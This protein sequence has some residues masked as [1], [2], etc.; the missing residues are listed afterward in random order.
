MKRHIVW[1]MLLLV[2]LVW[3]GSGQ[4]GP[5]SEQNNAP[6]M[7]IL[8]EGNDYATRVLRD[9][10]DMNE[11]SDISASLNNSGRTNLLSNIQVSNGVFSASSTDLNQAQFYA[12]FPG[13]E[14]EMRIGKV[15]EQYPIP[16]SYHCL[17]IR[18]RVN[19][20]STSDSWHP[21]WLNLKQ[22]F[23]DGGDVAPG[24]PLQPSDGLPSR[25]WRVYFVDLSEVNGFYHHPWSSQSSWKGLGIYPTSKPNTAFS[26]DWIRLTDC[27]AVNY[28][29]SWGQPV[30]GQS[31]LWA[32]IGAQQ[33]D[34][35]IKN[36]GSNDA[37]YT[38]DVQGIAPGTYYIGIES[39]SGMTWL[40][41][42]LV[43]KPTPIVNFTR[44]SPS[45]GPDYATLAGHPWNMDSSADVPRID[46]TLASFSNGMLVLD[47]PSPT[48][49]TPLPGVRCTGQEL[50][51]ADPRLFLY[52]P[53]TPFNG[54]DYRYLS[55]RMFINGNMQEVADGMIGR[56]IWTTQTG[57]T[58]VSKGI[59]YDVGWHT[60][61]VDLFDPAQGSP[62]QG[63]CVLQPWSSATQVTQLRFDPNENYTGM[64]Y[65]PAMA[66]HQEYDW[67]RLT[68]V[69]R[70]LHGT[71]FPIHI[72][73]NVPE[74]QIKSLNFYYTTSRQEPTQHSV[75]LYVPPSPPSTTNGRF[76]LYLP[77]VVNGLGDAIS[78]PA[79]MWETGNVA[80]GTYYVCANVSDGYNQASYCS[81]APL[82]IQ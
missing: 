36:L 42:N 19:S 16:S 10:W 12:L 5:L 64:G 20:P 21:A 41:N 57:C 8:P 38:W 59:P 30:G 53:M 18:M 72:S 70:V 56:W 39:S 31:K 60:Y 62:T 45:S 7:T 25:S 46:C 37:S 11:F 74:D 44:P 32:G 81:D 69:D 28:S 77:L 14:F 78:G 23:S 63:S 35:L 54:A 47:T 49:P 33:K 68:Q 52:T 71:A 43:I 17:Y 61:S 22:D 24:I 55:F 6:A 13:Y 65:V 1:G 75:T 34:I 66:F 51:E 79:Y 26:V 15:G 4:A 73:L 48:Q 76:R 50:G 40:P 67:F 29:I 82:L 27:R 80:P 3:P 58:Y 9:P 2:L